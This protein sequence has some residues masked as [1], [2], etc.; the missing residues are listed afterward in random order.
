MLCLSL[1]STSP[2]QVSSQTC[3]SSQS[4]YL[5]CTSTAGMSLFR[6]SAQ[7][8]PKRTAEPI[9]TWTGIGRG[10]HCGLWSARV[11]ADREQHAHVP[12]GGQAK[13]GC[14]WQASSRSLV[15]VD[16]VTQQRSGS[17][18][19]DPGIQGWGS[20]NMRE[21]G[22]GTRVSRIKKRDRTGVFFSWVRLL[23]RFVW[24]RLCCLGREL[25]LGRSAGVGAGGFEGGR[26]PP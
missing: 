2:L 7:E 21:A 6:Q 15:A 11:T 3:T 1:D 12:I 13:E 20:V 17:M 14:E 10:W 23:A 16:M 5:D 4:M 9:A 26:V 22:E 8:I 25:L 24:R 19:V 18:Q